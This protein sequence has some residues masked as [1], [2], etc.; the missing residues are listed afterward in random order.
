MLW[1]R[2]FFRI[3]LFL[4]YLSCILAA[5]ANGGNVNMNLRKKAEDAQLN[6]KFMEA[7]DLY[8][9]LIGLEPSA[10]NYFKRGSLNMRR[11][12]F[13]AALKDMSQA[14]EVDPTK[15][16]KKALPHIARCK[17]ALGQCAEAIIDY[18]DVL[19]LDSKNKKALTQLPQ[20]QE[21]VTHKNNADAALQ[22]HDYVKAK[23]ALSSAKEF[24][25]YDSELVSKR[26]EVLVKLGD[27]QEVL[28]DT[29]TIL[30]EDK[31]NLAALAA[32][33]QAFYSLNEH[34]TALSHYKE[35]LRSD[36]D[37]KQLKTLYKSLQ[38][39]TRRLKAGEKSFEQRAYG[40]AA[41]AY[42]EV[43]AMDPTHTSFNAELYSKICDALTKGQEGKQAVEACN[44][45][46][47]LDENNSEYVS[48]CVCLV[49]VCIYC[50]S[51]FFF[52]FSLPVYLYIFIIITLF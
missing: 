17:M 4:S 13:S 12:K 46:L 45:A 2:G 3:V 19:K 9:Q 38:K 43:I 22:R 32:R 18:Q 29:R 37:H 26:I 23:A 39:Y 50:C 44:E 52:V 27:F 10:A 41:E 6:G 11:K 24:A 34:D 21:C 49:C 40:E 42:R 25:P 33:G 31:S 14:K 35:G 20:A 16:T 47:K 1:E 5:G 51:L 36:P 15:Y 8:T 28:L 30:Q 7:V 48:M